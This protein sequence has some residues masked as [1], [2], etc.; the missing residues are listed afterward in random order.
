[1]EEGQRSRGVGEEDDDSGWDAI[2]V[3]AAAAEIH[4]PLIDQLRRPGR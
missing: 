2:H 3:G 1:V 4:Q